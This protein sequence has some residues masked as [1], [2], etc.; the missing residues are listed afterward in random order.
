MKTM[1]KWIVTGISGSGRIEILKE[2]E[3][4]ATETLGKK[5]RVYD[6]GNLLREECNKRSMNLVDELILDIDRP[7]LKVLR[8]NVLKNVKISVLE[9]PGVDLH[10][11]GVHATFRWKNR[12]IPG[13][14]YQ[15]VLDL[16]PDGFINIHHNLDEIYT[17]N[18]KN[19]KWDINT[20]PEHTETQAWMM[21][22]ELVTEILAEVLD[23]PVYLVSR[24]HHVHNFADIFFSNKKKVY[25]SYP[26]TAVRNENSTLLEKIQGPILDRLEEM[27]VVFNPLTI[28]DMP[29]TAETVDKITE[30]D[31]ETIKAR[32]VERDYQFID[33]SNGVVVF[34]LTDKVS[35]G[36]LAEINYAH[37]NQTPVFI[38][39]PG[40]QSPFL[41]EMATEVHPNLECLMQSLEVFAKR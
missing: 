38:T 31:K 13:I 24:E 2:L 16:K 28:T 40:K 41:M 9:E 29:L 12:I 37:R 6:V 14:C 18:K 4:Y 19:P 15:D 5:V 1:Q 3:E 34:Y 22:E 36:V 21:E 39:F 23:V 30:N 25:L 7:L 26:I 10:L 8:A 17:T 32:T 33:Q 11:I 20:L 27:F 35:P